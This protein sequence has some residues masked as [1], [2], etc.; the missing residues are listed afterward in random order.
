MSVTTQVEPVGIEQL[1][2]EVRDLA[3]RAGAKWAD[4]VERAKTWPHDMPCG[5]RRHT[6]LFWTGYLNALCSVIATATGEDS[7]VLMHHYQG[8]R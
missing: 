6:H 1:L 7:T 2:D 5:E 3:Q 8:T 4:E